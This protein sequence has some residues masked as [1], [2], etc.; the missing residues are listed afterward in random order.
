MRKLILGNPFPQ[1][2]I[3]TERERA[4]NAQDLGLKKNIRYWGGERYTQHTR[5]LCE[6][7]ES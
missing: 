5:G 3:E 1:V 6:G 7:R 2:H 4:H